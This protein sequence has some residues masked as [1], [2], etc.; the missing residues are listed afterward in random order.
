MFLTGSTTKSHN[1]TSCPTPAAITRKVPLVCPMFD[2]VIQKPIWTS[3]LSNG[4][5][6]DSG[7]DTKH[8]TCSQTETLYTLLEYLASFCLDLCLV[9]TRPWLTQMAFKKTN[10]THFPCILHVKKLWSHPFSS[11]PTLKNKWTELPHSFLNYLV[12]RWTKPKL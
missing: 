1:M 8:R 5:L 7:E 9:C 4:L 3:L 12:H 6:M 10:V 11:H 2:P